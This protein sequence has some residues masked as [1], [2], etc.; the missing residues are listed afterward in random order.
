MQFSQQFNTF[1]MVFTQNVSNLNR[2]DT[3]DTTRMKIFIKHFSCLTYNSLCTQD[4]EHL[5]EEAI[6]L[7]NLE[8][9]RAHSGHQ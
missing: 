6:Y 3:L 2:G 4:Q 8:R 5:Q 7:Q 9:M 1:K